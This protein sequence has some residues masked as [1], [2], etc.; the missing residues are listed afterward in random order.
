MCCGKDGRGFPSPGEPRHRS[1][2]QGARE[3]GA[4]LVKASDWPPMHA[5][6]EQAT[7][8]GGRASATVRQNGKTQIQVDAGEDGQ[9]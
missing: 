4:T 3:H 2:L 6:E 9:G 8:A 1:T 5:A 7:A